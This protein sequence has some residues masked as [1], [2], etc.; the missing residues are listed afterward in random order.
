MTRFAGFSRS[1]V[2]A[3]AMLLPALFA[4]NGAAAQQAAHGG[5]EEGLSAGM[6]NPGYVEPP[7]WFKVSFLDLGDDLLEAREA[8]KGLM[9]Y[10]Y[11]DGCP[12]CQRL[13]E[14]NFGDAAIAD[15]AQGHFD[16]VS[17][18]MWGDREVTDL[19][20]TVRGEKAFAEFAR[21]MYTPTLILFDPSGKVALRINGYYP[22]KKFMAALEYVAGG[23]HREQRFGPWLAKREAPPTGG[24]ITWAEGFASTPADLSKRSAG[25]PLLVL[26]DEAGCA[27]CDELHRDGLPRSE[28][29]AELA[30]FDR[31]QL[32]RFGEGEVVTPGGERTSAKAWAEALGISYAPSLV[33]FDAE[34]REVFRAE[35]YLRPFH[36]RNALG[37]VASGAYR[38]Q[39][40]FQRYIEGVADAMRERGEVVD[41]LR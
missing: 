35:A 14:E 27:P 38:E 30:R 4:W 39:P 28:V 16:V 37:Y 24:T 8:G 41:L 17:L 9:L 1:S 25:R 10:F 3:L 5:A 40:S 26:F 6:E 18:N 29:R 13:L 2:A 19:N 12:Y 34:G 22:P 15:F 7:E 23:H 21:V 36:L 33:M 11:Q 20:G 31:L 32:D